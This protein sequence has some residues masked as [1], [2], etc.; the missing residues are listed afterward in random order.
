MKLCVC[1]CVSV[2]IYDRMCACLCI[3][4]RSHIECVHTHI[5]VQLS[6]KP[7]PDILTMKGGIKRLGSPKDQYKR[8]LRYHH[9]GFK[10]LPTSTRLSASERTSR[11]WV[12]LWLLNNHLGEINH[13]QFIGTGCQYVW[14]KILLEIFSLKHWHE[15]STSG[16]ISLENQ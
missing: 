8:R 14:C 2:P 10:S 12:E 3:C 4:S 9:Q 1:V 6:S 16:W 7:F 11:G 13:C 5:V 15:L